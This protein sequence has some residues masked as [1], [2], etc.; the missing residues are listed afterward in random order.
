MSDGTRRRPAGPGKGSRALKPKVAAPVPTDPVELLGQ[1]VGLS[2]FAAAHVLRRAGR[3]LNVDT[4]RDLLFHLPRRY[5]DLR[6]MRQLGD[7][8][9][10]PDGAIVSAKVRVTDIRV[11]QTFRRRVQVTTASLADDT[12]TAEATWFGRRF[13]ERRLH[14]GDELIVSGKLKHRG[15]GIVFDD[16]EFQ[17][18]DRGSLLHVGRIVPVYRLT[19]GLTA[20][21]LRQAMR[22]ALDKAGY[23]Y[24]EY[25]P[26]G[27]RAAEDLPPIAEALEHAH[28]PTTF[29]ARDAA[30][31]RLA[32]DELLALQL[33]MVAR[34][35]AR[36]RARTASIPAD[37]ALDARIR[38][39]LEAS[40]ARKLGREAPLTDDQATVIDEIRGDLARPI[41]MLRLVQG[42]VGSGKTAVAAWALAAAALDGRQAALLAP[43][44]LLARQH[45]ATLGDLLEDLGAPGHAA[46][47]V[48]VRRG[49]AQGARGDRVGPG[50]RSSWA[51]TPCSRRPC[52]SRTSPS[53][54]STSS[55]GSGWSSAARSRRRRPAGC[56]T[57]CS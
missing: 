22:E 52:R 27:I 34:R 24:P 31:R 4:V 40:L 12:G 51:P 54:S 16:P 43:T 18:A 48:A 5:D 7:L 38:A 44:D 26:A 50:R 17:R 46:H 2:G 25:L 11:Q 39:A 33:G 36:G 28:Y 14:A 47:R 6:E 57:S 32:F 8:H 35:R 29:E 10:A 30:L 20:A 15:F 49:P 23:A 56:P 41:P 42:D 53:P 3:R 1:P 19:S 21:R 9:A 37:D 55:T 13:I 45:A